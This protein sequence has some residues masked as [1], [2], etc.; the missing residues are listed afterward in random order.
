[1]LGFVEIAVAVLIV[2]VIVL[3]VLGLLKPSALGRLIPWV[4]R[5]QPSRK[6]ALVVLAPVLAV[7]VVVQVAVL[8]LPNFKVTLPSGNRVVAHQSTGLRIAIGNTGLSG[9]QYSAAYALDG[10]KQSD[11][12]VRVAGGST[13]Q[14]NVPLPS[15]LTPGSHTVDIGSASLK[16][17]ALRPAAFAVTQL[18]PAVAMAKTGQE[19][20]VSA[21]VT[22]TGEAPGE[23]DGVLFADNKRYDAQPTTIAPGAQQALVFTFAS[24]SQGKHQLRLGNAT[25]PLVVVKPIH[26]ANGHYLHRTASGG[27]GILQIK[28][29][30]RVDGVVVLTRTSARHVPVIACYV[31]AR[32]SFTV[33]GIPDGTYWI[34][35]TL[36]RDWN[37]YTDGFLST[38]E[39]GLFH[40]PDKFTT[41]TWTTSWTTSMYRYTQGHVRYS[42]WTIT[43][44]PV[45][46][47]N[48]QT[49]T[50]S[51]NG[52]PRVH[53]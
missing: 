38:T 14:I 45:A 13:A 49:D 6:R 23:F 8:S 53:E 11:I 47:G 18:A 32:K 35:Y 28:N 30:N 9:G 5:P 39:R 16:I 19:V 48:A 27:S 12:A 22:N 31:G 15:G 46:G 7:L 17:T 36:G 43:L 29:G 2:V 33:A 26:F 1:M 40:S 42:G 25:H 41:S 51:E 20:T 50:V 3:L 24:R 34:Y 44:N 4:G 37:T 21:A 52:F 10:T